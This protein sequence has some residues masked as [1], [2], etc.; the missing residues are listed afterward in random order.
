MGA[1]VSVTRTICSGRVLGAT[2]SSRAPGMRSWCDFNAAGS[3]T[4]PT[5]YT[6]NKL[7]IGR[8]SII[9]ISTMC[10]RDVVGPA[11][12]WTTRGICTTQLGDVIVRLK[13]LARDQ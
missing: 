13:W 11:L 1:V 2:I 7:N 6:P 10:R 12:R 4:T 8:G 9:T 3:G 5:A